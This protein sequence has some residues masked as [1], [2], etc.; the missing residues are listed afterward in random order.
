[1]NEARSGPILVEAVQLYSPE[2]YITDDKRVT[3]GKCF[4]S[5]GLDS[6]PDRVTSLR[7]TLTVTVASHLVSVEKRLKLMLF[8]VM[9]E[10]PIRNVQ[11][12]RSLR[13]DPIRLFQC[14]LKI[15]LLRLRNHPLKVD[16]L[17]KQIPVTPPA[18]C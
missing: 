4:R 3:H 10:R 11:D 15:A 13:P 1:V 14:R 7:M 2:P 12:L 8:C 18:I 6:R 16:P 17:G 9:P 5:K